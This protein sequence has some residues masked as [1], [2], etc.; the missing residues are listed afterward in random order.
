MQGS[1]PH[2][3]H[4]SDGHSLKRSSSVGY[5]I[6]ASSCNQ[7][8][9]LSNW[10]LTEIPSN[11]RC[12]NNLETQR[13]NVEEKSPSHGEVWCRKNI[14]EINY[15]C[16]LYGPRY[17]ASLPHTYVNSCLI[18]PLSTSGRLAYL[19][20]YNLVLCIIDALIF[21]QWMLSILMFVSWG[22]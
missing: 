8:L 9:H 13:Q 20:S 3:S 21:L 18:F 17:N 4:T 16:Q 14:D 2:L 15:I 10:Q 12:P 11:C 22:I 7:L 5:G 19:H 6:R 1:Y